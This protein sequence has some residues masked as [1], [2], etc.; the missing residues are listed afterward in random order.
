MKKNNK[1]TVGQEAYSRL[2]K[3]PEKADPIELQRA[4]HEDYE[5]N[6]NECI[7]RSLKDYY[8]DFYVVVTTKKE[9]IMQNVLRNYFFGRKSCPTPEYDQ[10]VYKYT[11]SGGDLEFLWVVPSKDTCELLR[12]NALNVAPEERVLRDFVLEFYDGT[13]L[14]KSKGLNG[15]EILTPLLANNKK[16]HF[17]GV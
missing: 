11:R 8:G 17:K 10:T 5:K 2:I 7:D 14:K 3:T 6:I 1:K 13:L 4:M 15:E 12:D 16:K 9:R